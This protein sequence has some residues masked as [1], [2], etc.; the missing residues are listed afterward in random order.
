MT[1]DHRCR[2]AARAAP[3][4]GADPGAQGSLQALRRRPGTPRGGLRRPRRRG[5]GARRRQRR[6]QVR[7]D[8]VHRRHLPDRRRRDPLRGQAGLR[9][10]GRRTRRRS[11]SRSSTRTSRSPT[12]STSSRTCTSAARRSRRCARST[13]RRWSSAA[14]ETLELAVGDDDP[15]GAPDRRRPL[16]RP[17]PVDRGRQ[18]RHVELAPR[19]PR[20]ADRGARRRPDAA[21]ARPRPA[22]RR[23]GPRGRASSRTTCTTSSRSPTA[24]RSC[25]SARTSRASTRRRRPSARSSRRSP[26]ARSRN[27]PGQEDGGDRMSAITPPAARPRPPRRRRRSARTPGAGGTNVRGGELGSLPIIVGLLVIAIVFQSQ[28]DQLPDGRQLRQPHGPGRGVRDR[29]R[30]ASSSSCCSA[31]STCRSASSRAS[32]AS[33]ARCCCCPTATTVADGGRDRRGARRGRRDRH[34]PR[35]DHHEGRHPVVRRD[36]RRPARLERRRAAAHRQP[37]HRRPAGRLR[38]RLRQ[39]LP[40]RRRRRGCSCCVAVGAYAAVQIW[41]LRKRAERRPAE[42]PDAHRRRC[43]SAALFVALAFVVYVVNQDRGLPYVAVLVGVLLVFWTYVLRRTR[44]GRHVYAVGGNAEAARRA[45]INVD[46]IKII[47]LRDLLA[48]WRRS[49][50]SCSPRACARSTRT[51]AAARSCC[52]RSPRRSS[53]ARRCSAAAGTSSPR[54]SARSSSRRIDNGLGLLGLSSGDEVRRHRL[55]AAARRRRRLD[56]APRS[57]AVRAEHDRGHGRPRRARS[58]SSPAPAAA[59]APRS[60]AGWRTRGVALG[61]ASRSGD[62]LGIE[63]AVAPRDRRPRSRGRSRRSSTATVAAH[64]GLDIVVANAGVGAYG[65]F[66]ELDP[67]QLELMIDVNLKGDA[68]HRARDAAAPH[69]TRAAATSSRWR[70]SPG[71]NAFPGEAVYN[72][73]KFGQVGFT[74]SLD[75]E[76]R[77]HGVRCTNICPGRRRDGLRDRHRARR[78]ACRSSTG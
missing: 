18:G 70:R 49:A 40:L 8:Q 27:V 10:T 55:R 39:R 38:H 48:A 47:V 29:S 25:A 9:S 42:R 63:G 58:R 33:S 34:V 56:L 78:R 11:G 7:D 46:R 74:R 57:R 67:E 32:R 76:L 20:R 36:A 1:D 72:A 61:L 50:A 22:P 15:L 77:E 19:H 37:R 43:G 12:T 23:A 17:A 5:H 65:P 73:S 28:N 69:R 13:R 68:L 51:R 24:S 54:C 3:R 26:P 21:G 16:G 45:G 31:R 6:R 14:S 59:S 64:G 71:V 60:R 41:G 53:A 44:F 66:L 35:R 75:I 4:R 30:W 2:G 52:T 62:D